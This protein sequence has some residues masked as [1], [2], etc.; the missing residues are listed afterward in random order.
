MTIRQAEPK[1][2]RFVAEFILLAM[3]DLAFKFSNSKDIEFTLSLF[4]KFVAKEANQY[5]FE[6]TLVAEQNGEILGAIIGY[7][8]G[9]LDKF[10]KPFMEYIRE[11]CN[12][13]G[14]PEDETE[15]GEVYLDTLAVSPQHQGKKIGQKLIEALIEQS[16]ERGF[17]RVGLLVDPDNPPAKRLYERIGFKVAGLK[18]LMGTTYEHMVYELV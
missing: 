16:R 17:P 2:A 14:N 12:F 5:S 13:Q 7:D 10:R 15:A 18:P 1:D 3:N 4:E 11:N 6:N 8:G 9:K